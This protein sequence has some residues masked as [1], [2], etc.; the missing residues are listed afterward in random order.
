MLLKVKFQIYFKK[1]FIIQHD[2]SFAQSFTKGKY[3]NWTV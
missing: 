2:N 1:D 3:R